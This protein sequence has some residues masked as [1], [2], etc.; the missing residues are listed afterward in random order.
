MELPKTQRPRLLADIRA[1]ERLQNI[2]V[3]VLTASAVH[4]AVLQAQDLARRRLH[5]QARELGTIHQRG[6][7]AAEILARGPVFSLRLDSR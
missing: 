4:K 3:I 7:V 5:D 1:D 2:P 6:Q